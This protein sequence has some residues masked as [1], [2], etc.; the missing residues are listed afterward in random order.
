MSSPKDELTN[1]EL[2]R[3][4]IPAGLVIVGWIIVHWLSQRRELASARRK[5]AI[6]HCDELLE[7]A[8]AALDEAIEYHNQVR[9]VPRE[10]KL[11]SAFS[12]MGMVASTLADLG[13]PVDKYLAIIR[14]HNSFKRAVTGRHFAE[15][16]RA[17]LQSG[18]QESVVEM[19]V[20]CSELVR[21]IIVA[22]A[23]C[24]K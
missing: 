5:T 4:G 21:Q 18:D 16:H 19:E 8:N 23:G 17:A 10:R 11:L 9:D 1:A 13:V 24:L 14:A 12:H 22:R 3:V 15:E 20:A 6:E 2:A 7:K